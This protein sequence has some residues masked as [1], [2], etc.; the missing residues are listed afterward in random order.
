MIL[1]INDMFQKNIQL[2][3]PLKGKESGKKCVFPFFK[4]EN[5]FPQ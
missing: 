2:Q 5:I 3:L 1:L 4:K